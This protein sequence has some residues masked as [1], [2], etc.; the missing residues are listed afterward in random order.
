MYA[1]ISTGKDTGRKGSIGDSGDIVI[2]GSGVGDKGGPYR[3]EM[4]DPKGIRFVGE[5]QLDLVVFM[6]ST[7]CGQKLQLKRV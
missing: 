4:A 3:D 1:G 5:V 2:D 7:F 6:V